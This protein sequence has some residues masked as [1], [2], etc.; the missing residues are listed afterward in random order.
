MTEIP[1]AILILAAG[2]SRRMRG[3]DKML[4]LVAGDVL[5]RHQVLKA[6]STGLPVWV[7]LPPDRP[8]RG[9]A[10]QG[11]DATRIEVADAAL[12]L[13]Y[14]IKAGNA[15]VPLDYALILWLADLPEIET[16]DLQ[17]LVH[18]ANAAQDR[19]VRATTDAGKPGHPVLIPAAFRAELNELTGDNG[20]RKMLNRRQDS[21]VFVPLPG[22][23]ALT[24][25]DTPEDWAQWRSRVAR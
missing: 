14:S 13:S 7:A 25:L 12:G 16:S 9:L 22:N 3:A 8:L 1:A 6:I 2:Q 24:D 4:E 21:T 11:L 10:L 15:A 18:A 17:M 20:A 23:R 19:I 5:I